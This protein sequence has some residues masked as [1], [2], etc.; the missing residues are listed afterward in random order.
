[1]LHASCSQLC[2]SVYVQVES[3]VIEK[4]VACSSRSRTFSTFCTSTSNS[5]SKYSPLSISSWMCLHSSTSITS[6]QRTVLLLRL[7]SGS[8]LQILLNL[9]W[10]LRLHHKLRLRI[11]LMRKISHQL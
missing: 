1:M 8:L 5:A 6:P 4:F 7:H 3:K 11:L 2:K 9:T 10:P